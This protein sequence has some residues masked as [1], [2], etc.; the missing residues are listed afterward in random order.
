M[1]TV[2]VRESR[3]GRQRVGINKLGKSTLSVIL[4]GNGRKEKGTGKR[5]DVRG[6][7]RRVGFV[8]LE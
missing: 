1:K 7:K 6:R 3:R 2:R 8:Y 5:K 4:I